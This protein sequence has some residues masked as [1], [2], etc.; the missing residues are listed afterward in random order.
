MPPKRKPKNSG[1]SKRRIQTVQSTLGKSCTVCGDIIP[2]NLTQH[3]RIC[4]LTRTSRR[5]AM[6]DVLRNRIQRSEGTSS[7]VVAGPSRSQAD[8]LPRPPTPP[9]HHE[10][11]SPVPMD[12]DD[13]PEGLDMAV[14]LPKRFIYVKHHPHAQKAD[15]IIPLDSD[16]A[17]G[18]LP[19]HRVSR[20][21]TVPGDRP[22]APF[23]CLADSTFAYRCVAG[24][25]SNKDVD[26]DLKHMRG[27]WADRVNITFQN[28]RD[29]EK[30][31]A[32]ARV[33]NVR[34]CTKQVRID[35]DGHEFSEKVYDLEIEFRNPWEVMKRWIRDESLA[36]VSTW[37]SQQR[38]LC[39]DGVID[40]SN[41]L[42]DEPCTA[43]S[44]R[45][46]DDSLPGDG[47]YPSCYVP[48]H[49][50][51]DKSLVSTKV[52]M[53]P[54]LLR[55]CQ[56]HS[57]TRNGSGN[58]GATLLGFVKMPPVLR[59]IDPKTL[60][61]NSRA[62]YDR[63]KRLIYHTVCEVVL[64]SLESRSRNGEAIRFGDG[65]TRIAH[66]GILIESMDFEEV[67]AWLA[68]RNSQA[69]HPCPSCLI[70]HDDLHKL[71]LIADIRT[72]ASMQRIFAKASMLTATQ[73]EELLKSYG[74]HF[75]ELFLWRFD[76]SDPYSAV[77]YDLLHYFDSGIW[78][79]HVWPCLKQYLQA[80]KLG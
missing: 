58:G 54:I 50:W 60:S 62:E 47:R 76:H 38:F 20:D 52:K 24:R 22:W 4:K 2:K 6:E 63:L 12:I 30:S 48:A 5:Q 41:P 16:S 77:G 28:H 44:W 67:A 1:R 64:G 45:K 11:F 56:I 3:E 32:A 23:R 18:A 42:Y 25:M 79:K 7:E 26:N 53:H 21:C 72:S 51:L 55:D 71:S 34:F 15:E 73:R 13:P 29:M 70:S 8:L 57:T 39:L 43:E 78:G 40:F 10:S 31:L 69:N 37:F 35:F 65:V 80:E 9:I 74:L 14:H 33:G 36:E 75:F 17:T 19:A 27:D 61:G 49:I 66:P 68:I 59:D 46:V